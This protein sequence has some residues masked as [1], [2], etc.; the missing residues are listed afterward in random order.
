MYD[1]GVM[2]TISNDK[3]EFLYGRQIDVEYVPMYNSNKN[4]YSN[5]LTN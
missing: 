3:K 2:Q 4:L 5:W 1:T